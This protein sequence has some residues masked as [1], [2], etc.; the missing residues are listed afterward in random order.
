[1]ETSHRNPLGDSIRSWLD[2]CYSGPKTQRVVNEH[3]CL[4]AE[5][6]PF[7]Y[8][9]APSVLD[10]LDSDR[11]GSTS[12]GLS[13]MAGGAAV[14]P[15]VHWGC[16]N[17]QEGWTLV[18]RHWMTS[19]PL[20]S[21]RKQGPISQT[22]PVLLQYLSFQVTIFSQNMRVHL[23]LGC[24]ER[25]ST[26]PILG[27]RGSL[28]INELLA[29]AQLLWRVSNIPASSGAVL[30]STSSGCNEFHEDVQ[31]HSDPLCFYNGLS[32]LPFFSQI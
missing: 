26:F 28:D 30:S 2:P 27:W 8:T 18:H 7:I 19:W 9:E 5:T 14:P 29:N 3:V 21:F 24:L 32:F 12:V 4:S 13:S 25:R 20:E 15:G 10:P 11:H 22:F 17:G 1:M 6:F 23:I 31:W 16:E